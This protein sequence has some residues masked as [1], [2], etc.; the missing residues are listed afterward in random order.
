MKKEMPKLPVV[1]QSDNRAPKENYSRKNILERFVGGETVYVAGSLDHWY[2]AIRGWQL[3]VMGSRIFYKKIADS[4]CTYK[5]GVFYGTFNPQII[6]ALIKA[7]KLDWIT[8]SIWARNALMT[9]KDLWKMVFSGKITNPELLAKTISKRY[10]QGKYTYTS[11]KVYYKNQGISLWDLFYYTTNPDLALRIYCGIIDSDISRSELCDVVR[12]A[13]ILDE[14]INPNWSAKRMIAEHQRQ[15]EKLNLIDIENTS[16]EP[17][18]EAFSA[19]GLSLVLDERSCYLEGCSMHNCVHSYY[20]KHIEKG[21][22]ILA[23][24]TVNEEYVD[25]GISVCASKS[26]DDSPLPSYIRLEI[27]QIHTIYNGRVNSETHDY[28]E[29]WLDNHKATLI[30]IV[31]GIRRNVDNGTPVE[32]EDILPF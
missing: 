11:L 7:F 27:D 12:G 16:P 5:G 25:F 6:E 10:F 8:K 17:I 15:I 2:V 32:E 3:S 18:A 26:Y 31:R 9:R 24:G 22:Y 14:K 29:K 4:S 28:C 20:W 19:E 13:K 30:R 1:F 23:R 21:D